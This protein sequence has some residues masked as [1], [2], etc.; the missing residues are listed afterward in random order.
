MARATFMLTFILQYYHLLDF[1]QNESFEIWFIPVLFLKIA[2]NGDVCVFCVCGW[3]CG[4]LIVWASPGRYTDFEEGRLEVLGEETPASIDSLQED[5]TNTFIH[6]VH[7]H[8]LQN[9]KPEKKITRCLSVC[10]PYIYTKL[11]CCYLSF[12]SSMVS[13]QQMN[14]ILSSFFHCQVS[15]YWNNVWRNLLKL[16]YLLIFSR[17]IDKSIL[18]KAKTTEIHMHNTKIKLALY[19]IDLPL[20]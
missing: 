4:I 12:T 1:T 6:S 8:T 5:C 16:K 7:A 3:V 17:C 14:D 10:M 2:G 13:K 9:H 20:G 15:C 11:G 18:F 19:P